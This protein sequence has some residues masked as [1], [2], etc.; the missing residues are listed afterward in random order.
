MEI[1]PRGAPAS[2]PPAAGTPYGRYRLLELLGSGG[3]AEVYRAV[4]EGPLGFEKVVAI[5]RIH[6]HLTRS[7]PRVA[8]T[9]INEAHLGALLQHAHLVHL[10]DFGEVEG[11]YFLA[12]EYVAGWTLG[13][14]ISAQGG[15]GLAAAAAC[16]LFVQVADGL[17]Y[18]H[19]LA[20]EDG[21]PL[22]LIHR[23]LK[24]ANVMVD[25]RGQAKVLDFGIAKGEA[26]LYETTSTSSVMGTPYYMSP[27]QARGQPLDFRSDQFS[28]GVVLYETLT[29]DVLFRAETLTQVLL[30]VVQGDIEPKLAPLEESAPALLPILRRMLDR[31][32][33]ARFPTTAGVRDAL[34]EVRGHLPGESLAALMARLGPRR[35]TPPPATP[36]EA[37]TPRSTPAPVGSMP[38]MVAAGEGGPGSDP[39]ATA[40]SLG[41]RRPSDGPSG[42]PPPAPTGPPAGTGP[43]GRGGRAFPVLLGATGVAVAVVGAALL[44]LRPSSTDPPAAP[45]A[46]APAVAPERGTTAELDAAPPRT[47]D[48][49]PSPIPAAG[50]DPPPVLHR[51]GGAAGVRPSP[52]PPGRSTGAPAAEV[53]SQPIAA[54]PAA[55]PEPPDEVAPALRHA[56]IRAV[57]PGQPINVSAS[58]EA[59]GPAEVLCRYWATSDPGSAGQVRLLPVG[60]LWYVSIP[61]KDAYASGFE[62]FVFARDP[63]T[64][65]LLGSSGSAAS[66]HRASP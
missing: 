5:K 32:P 13:D 8:R 59:A 62:Y 66:P 42:P 65:A 45:P 57:H 16:D 17:A 46:A 64:R 50:T 58:L 36:P 19:T 29:G 35:R 41:A 48:P 47:P 49:V 31:D 7:N 34:A 44:G 61:W 25:A 2:R 1:E 39:L 28:L 20:N 3:M 40:T 4:M 23:D 52:P 60:G 33:A 27:E 21:A 55:P 56:P 37:L 6:P 9:I 18:A 14:L 10:V 53:R 63:A 43:A 11:T 26:A 38:S 54:A 15:R 12:M 51:A 24:P 30:Q 22:R